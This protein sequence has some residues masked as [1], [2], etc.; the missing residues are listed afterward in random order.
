MADN[1]ETVILDV[2]LD[3]QKVSAELNDVVTRIAALKAQQADL[4]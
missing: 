1:R 4:T 3:A 2:Q